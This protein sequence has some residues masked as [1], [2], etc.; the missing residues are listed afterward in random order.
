MNIIQSLA[1][2]RVVIGVTDEYVEHHAPKV[3]SSIA[4]AG[5]LAI[6]QQGRLRAPLY[7]RHD[8]SF[9]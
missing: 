5:P 3:L 1:T 6:S 4:G 2:G 8:D 7:R 9:Q